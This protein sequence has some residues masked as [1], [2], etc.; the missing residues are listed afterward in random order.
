LAKVVENALRLG[1]NHPQVKEQRRMI[2]QVDHAVA[3]KTLGIC[4]P[5]KC[6]ST[7][8]AASYLCNHWSGRVG[9]SIATEGKALDKL[10]DE[11]MDRAE[12]VKS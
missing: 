2:D 12:P 7:L 4:V 1:E 10:P 3:G 9:A 6:E 8:V 11:L 5:G